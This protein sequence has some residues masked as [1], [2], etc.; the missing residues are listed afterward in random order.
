MKDF[1]TKSKIK[2]VVI[3]P[4]FYFKFDHIPNNEEVKK[5]IQEFIDTKNINY[6]IKVSYHEEQ[7]GN[8]WDAETKQY[9]SWN[10]LQELAEARKSYKLMEES[11]NDNT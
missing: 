11:I 6:S 1:K 3:N 2:N 8:F 4:F 7:K 5:K 10:E 9:Y